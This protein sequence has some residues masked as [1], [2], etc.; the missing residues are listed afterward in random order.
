MLLL[1][2]M[3][4]VDSFKNRLENN[5]QAKRRHV[6]TTELNCLAAEFQETCSFILLVNT[7]I[8]TRCGH[9]GHCPRDK[10]GYDGLMHIFSLANAIQAEMLA[11][12]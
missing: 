9:S 7:H 11:K 2:L 10:T 12:R 1:K 6:L 8:S 4:S 5:G 3:Y